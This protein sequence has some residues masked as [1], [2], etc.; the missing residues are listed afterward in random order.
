[1]TLIGLQAVAEAQLFGRRHDEGHVVEQVIRFVMS[2]SETKPRLR[3]VGHG[4][5][6]RP[7]AP[8]SARG[9][10]PLQALVRVAPQILSAL[11]RCRL[12]EAL[13]WS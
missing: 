10:P 1:V 6:R 13:M 9:Q 2:G 12:E 5:P 8:P 3:K 4:A 7:R 11:C